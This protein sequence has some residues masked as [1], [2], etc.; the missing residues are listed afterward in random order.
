MEG[1]SFA[2]A[3]GGLAACASQKASDGGVLTASEAQGRMNAHTFRAERR[4]IETPFAKIAYVERGRGDA[5]L[6]LHGYPLNGFQWRGAIERLSPYRRCI[7]ADFMGLGYTLTPPEQDLSPQSQTDML[8]A[9]LDALSIGAVDIVANDSGGTIAQLFVV[10]HPERV[11]T[12]LLTDCDVDENSPPA[13]L[14]PFIETAKS[15]R[16]ADEWLAPQLADKSVARSD[17]G[18]GGLAY[19]HPADFT[20]EAIEYYFSPLLSSALRKAQFSRY[21]VSFDPNPLI[22]IESALKRSPAPARI[23]WGTNDFLFDVSWA[24]WLD[25]TLPNS[26]GVRFVEGAKLFFPEE[27]PNLIAAEARNLWGVS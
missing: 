4:L 21:A 9:F 11:R 23:I 27:M 13:G 24:K 2:I 22:A 15:G 20:D 6:F 16:A 26:R 25:K 17:K 8:V 10:Q 3:T 19:T 1:G 18:L 5:A 14:R 7:A 12:L